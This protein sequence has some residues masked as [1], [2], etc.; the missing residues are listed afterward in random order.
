MAR[1][2]QLRVRTKISVFEPLF[3]G[4][5]LKSKNDDKERTWF[6]FSYEKIPHFCFDCGRLVHG[7]GVCIPPVEP[8]AQWGS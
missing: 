5:F 1:G 7:N 8:A 3:R 6:E 2:N 4:F